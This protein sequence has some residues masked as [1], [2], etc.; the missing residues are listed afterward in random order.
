MSWPVLPHGLLGTQASTGD[1]DTY[2]IERSLRF[3][4]ADLAHLN[5]TPSSA[6]NRRVFTFSA[7]VKL[8]KFGDTYGPQFITNQNGGVNFSDTIS[9]YSDSFNVW[10]AGATYIIRSTQVLRDSGSWYHLVAAIDTTQAT[11]AN[12][13]KLYINGVEVTSLSSSGYPPQN[14]D[15]GFNTASVHYIGQ[16]ISTY[17]SNM[18]LTEFYWIDGQALTPS[19]FGETDAITGRWKAKAYSGTYGTNGFYL[20]FK[21]NSNTSSLGQDQAYVDGVKA[22]NNFWTTNNFSVTAGAGNDSLVD[23][24]T[25]YG[26]DTGL[27]GEV[28]GNY[29]TINP[30]D[31][32]G[33]GTISNGNLQYVQSTLNARGGRGTIAVSSG[34]WYWEVTNNGGNN[35]VGVIKDT[36]A[37]NSTYIGGNADGWS[38]FID[39]S[40]Y[41]NNSSSTYGASYT[42]NDIIGIALNMDAGTLVFYKNGVS[43]GT[44]FTGLS[45]T[46]SPA[47]SSSLTSAVSFTANFGQRPFAYAAPSG[48]KALCTQNLPQPT[49]Q[50]P[51]TAMDVVTY[52]GN[53]STNAITGLGFSPE[54]V[55]IK[56]R[57][58]AHFH[59]LY[60]IVRGAG[61]TKGLYSNTTEAEGT[62]SSFQNFVS[63]DSSGFTLGSTTSTNNLNNNTSTYV[64]WSW[65]AGSTN[66]TNTSGSITST[67]RANTQAGFSIVSYTGN[68]TAGATVGHGLGVAPKMIIV[69]NRITAGFDWVTYHQN[70]NASPQGGYVSLNSTIAFT[71]NTGIWNNVA[72][73]SSVF[74]LGTNTAVNKNAEGHIAYCFAEI[75]GYSKFGS[76]TGNASADGPF[77]WC[78]FRPKYIM[79]KKTS[80]TGPWMV[81]DSSRDSFNVATSELRP[82]ETTAEPI[83]TRGSVDLLSNGFKIRSTSATFLGEL[84]D[85]IFAAFAESPF[86]YARAR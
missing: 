14:Y 30:L 57:S 80:A 81:F 33:A 18:Y 27:G 86:K 47:F 82:N 37:I 42:T 8:T 78:G 11:A 58:A 13:V 66:S 6:T 49:I 29:C 75:E 35:S 69:K 53:S 73:S 9:I 38:Y 26:E 24:P 19:S 32:S 17:Y 2:Q 67:V 59:G 48:F 54:F 21:N 31:F 16:L 68:G 34:K 50:K 74:T 51:S 10:F 61:N 7:W 71:S 72:P 41:N 12:R 3:N 55:W 15:T 23:S 22:Q 5:R 56:G 39:G 45:G 1:S 28:R 25:N 65:D 60:D 64:A 70:M 36:G 79:V 46:L 52:T 76:Y 4:S 44:A 83:A 40:K 62:N 63:F 77:V 85:F 84:G 20:S 43:Q